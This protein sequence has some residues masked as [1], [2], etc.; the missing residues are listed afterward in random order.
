M[1]FSSDLLD[2]GIELESP[3][4]AGGFFTTEPCGKPHWEHCNF[5]KNSDGP[6]KSISSL[7]VLPLCLG[8]TLGPWS[9]GGR[10]LCGRAVT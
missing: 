6:T 10:V 2:P 4:L 1:S 3:A 9:S 7:G 5:L 8:L